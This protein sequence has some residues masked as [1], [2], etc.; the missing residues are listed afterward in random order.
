MSQKTLRIRLIGT[1]LRL[2]EKKVFNPKLKRELL[3]A[4]TRSE[5]TSVLHDKDWI[6][7]DVGANRGQTINLLKSIFPN[8]LIYA[9]EPDP[10]IFSK[11]ERS[12]S[13]SGVKLF[14]VALGAAGG[15]FPFWVSPID[16]TS[17]LHLPDLESSWNRKKA[18]IL[19][20]KPQDMYQ[21]I[22]VE[23]KT[24]DEIAIEHKIDHID[25]LK[26]DV[27]G[28]ELQVLHGALKSFTNG[29]VL[30]VQF[31][32]HEDDLRPSQRLKIEEFLLEHGFQKC[33]QIKHA[34][35]SFYEE[36]WVSRT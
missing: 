1:V 32:N 4:L 21:R 20:L 35:G 26:I 31:E 25:L 16:E 18:A 27:E 34:F 3:K 7:F 29:I 12:S 11:L 23:V 24:L 13:K 33:S 19:G 14:N 17:T 22:E 5:D 10:V 15:R 28:A 6:F 9:F 30:A 36:L 8:S 2:L